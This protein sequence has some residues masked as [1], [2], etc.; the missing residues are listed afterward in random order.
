VTRDVGPRRKLLVELLK[1]KIPNNLHLHIPHRWWFV[2]DILITTIPEQILDFKKEIGE[3][4]LQLEPKRAR[5][6]LG[7]TGPTE[8]SIRVP[9]FEHLAG[10][11][12]TETIHK[13]LGCF[14]KLDAA[15]L[16]FSPG[17]HYERKRM[18]NKSK[19]DEFI[20]DM[21]SCVGNLSL[22]I[23][24]HN[25][26]KQIIAVEINPLAFK[27]LEESIILNKVE[28]RMKA[29]I[30]DNRLVLKQYEGKVDRVISGF[31]YSDED[32]IRQ[33]IRLCNKKGIIHYHVAITTKK[34][35]QAEVIMDIKRLIEAE[36][37][38][39]SRIVRKRV[40]KYSP[41]VEHIVLDIEIN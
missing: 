40:K 2:G 30:G 15:K 33:A 38:I 12:K 39:C 26:P 34:E 18:L 36:G 14:F 35:K 17:N 32:Q 9:G 21:F 19:K 31:L 28:D 22:P 24:V 13:E 5:V 8:G 16:T 3:A 37:R 20:V 1:D 4:F 10:D 7:K 27:Y 41:G 11:E 25:S 6:V 23:A 29:I